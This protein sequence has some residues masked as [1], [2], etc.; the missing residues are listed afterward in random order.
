MSKAVL[1][2]GQ[3]VPDESSLE[4]FLNANFDVRIIT[5]DT[6]PDALDLIRKSTFDLVLINRKLDADYT[7]GT[8]ILRLIKADDVISATPVMIVS[9]YPEYQDAAVQ[10][11][12]VYGFGKAELGRSDVIARL[13]PYLQSPS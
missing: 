12:A 5:A 10:M 4:R 3:C 7:D 1:S 11:G 13:N 6:A 2:V 8:E 9:N